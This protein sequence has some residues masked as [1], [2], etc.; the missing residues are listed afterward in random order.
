MV[1]EIITIQDRQ[2]AALVILKLRSY[3]SRK[4]VAEII[5]INKFYVTFAQKMTK[6]EDGEKYL[7][8]NK[9]IR[10]IIELPL[11]SIL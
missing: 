5:G 7:C 4:M 10:K 6:R 1:A 11:D 8:P 9:V 2:Q 3:Y